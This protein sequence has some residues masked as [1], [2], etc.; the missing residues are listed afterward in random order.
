M[1][2]CGKF[3]PGNYSNVQEAF[4]KR[5]AVKNSMNIINGIGTNV[6]NNDLGYRQHSLSLYR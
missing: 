5:L 1:L 4:R 6:L 3:Y 2:L